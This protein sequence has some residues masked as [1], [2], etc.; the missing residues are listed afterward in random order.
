ML[1][2]ADG[3]GLIRPFKPRHP[4]S[5]RHADD[6]ASWASLSCRPVI[7][8]L[9]SFLICLRFQLAAGIHKSDGRPH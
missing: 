6:V 2:D 4:E 3:D 5:W 8:V 1:G 7:S 9:P